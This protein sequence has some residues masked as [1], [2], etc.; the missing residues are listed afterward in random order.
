MSKGLHFLLL[1][2]SLSALAYGNWQRI[3]G[4]LTHITASVNYLWGV[5]RAHHIFKSIRV[6]ATD[7]GCM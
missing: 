3:P 7:P 4:G 2:S 5:N 1:C 6:L